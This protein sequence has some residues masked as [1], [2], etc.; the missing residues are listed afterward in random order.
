MRTNQFN[1]QASPICMQEPC[2]V[3]MLQTLQKCWQRSESAYA[4]RALTAMA[5]LQLVQQL[6][7]YLGSTK[8]SRI[9]VI[10]IK[11]PI[12]SQIPHIRDP[13][14]TMRPVIQMAWYSSS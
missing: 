10:G 4:L 11:L 9:P 14:V 8:Y 3:S 12:I 7:K 2:L 1:I 6:P 13:V 5:R